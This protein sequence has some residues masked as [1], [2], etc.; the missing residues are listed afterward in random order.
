MTQATRGCAV[1]EHRAAAAL[2]LRAA[3]VLRRAQAEVLAQH[4][5]Q[6]RAVVGHL[7]LPAV[8]LELERR[9]AISER[10]SVAG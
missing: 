6:R 9:R 7:D 10:P 4:L 8:D 2:A 3:P 1:D 5:E